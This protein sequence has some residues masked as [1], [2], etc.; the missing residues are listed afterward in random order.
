LIAT[1]APLRETLRML[2]LMIEARAD[3]LVASILLLGSDKK[4][5]HVGAAPNLPDE[6]NQSA[7]GLAIGPNV[8]SCGTAAY[9]GEPVIVTDIATDPRWETARDLALGF[10]LR[11]CWSTPI[12]SSHGDV[13]GT[14]ALYY[15]EPRAPDSWHRKLI[16]L[17][18]HLASVA[19]E[20]EREETERAHILKQERAARDRAE[21]L[22]AEITAIVRQVAEGIIVTDARG[23]ITFF[24]EAAKRIYGTDADVGTG[25]ACDYELLSLAG[26]A[27]PLIDRPLWRAAKN[28]ETVIDA[29]WRIRRADGAEIIA[30]GSASPVV[31][32]RG[33][34]V[35]AVLTVRDVT[36]Q[37]TIEREKDEF[38]AAA[39]HDLKGPL[40]VIKGSAE[41]LERRVQ[42]SQWTGAAWL[43]A[44]L[45]RIVGAS[46]TT[47]DLINE[48]LDIGRLRLGRPLELQC[49]PTD[50]V[51]LARQIIADYQVSTERHTIQL[52]ASTSSLV[53]T[54]DQARLLRVLGNLLSNAVKFSP[55]GGEISVEIEHQ[56][57][58]EHEWAVIKVRDFGVGIPASEIGRVFQRYHRAGN[59]VGRIKGSGIGLASAKFIVEQHGGTIHA[60]SAEG[61]GTTMTVR[62]PVT[63]DE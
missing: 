24:N 44:G 46:N 56:A 45:S 22:A 49:A 43:E 16:N 6:F 53:G 48:F 7:E 40:T 33:R 37:R 18:T 61:V 63:S 25:A 39:S 23:R 3:G 47:V 17:A 35:G 59:V 62:L 10:G 60:E 4:H 41:L 12:C 19:I 58:N 21:H 26:E 51:S 34:R 55:A 11:A 54:W 50:L 57:R 5:L 27:Y 29:E 8:G 36:T 28:G 31:S 9:L 42:T 14:F 30:Q 52:R 15:R 13:L 32:D 20:R 38:L 2:A 1:R